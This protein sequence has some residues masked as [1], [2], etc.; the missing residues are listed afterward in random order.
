MNTSLSLGRTLQSPSG[1]PHAVSRQSIITTI[2]TVTICP[3]RPVV[4]V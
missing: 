3:V 2:I 1:G 4:F